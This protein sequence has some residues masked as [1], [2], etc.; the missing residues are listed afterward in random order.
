MFRQINMNRKY[1][2]NQEILKHLKF[3]LN[4]SKALR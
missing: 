3:I 4:A 2:G 1:E